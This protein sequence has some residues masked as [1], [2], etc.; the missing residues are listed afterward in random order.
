MISFLWLFDKTWSLLLFESYGVSTILSI[1]VN[2]RQRY[3]GSATFLRSFSKIPTSVYFNSLANR[4]SSF[5]KLAI[6]LH[7]YLFASHSISSWKDICFIKHLISFD[8]MLGWKWF[9]IDTEAWLMFPKI[10]FNKSIQFLE[11]T[12]FFILPQWSSLLDFFNYLPHC[13]SYPSHSYC[14]PH[15][16]ISYTRVV[17]VLSIL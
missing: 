2:K 3:P 12:S 15:H 17:I 11:S 6:V 5:S 1:K 7:A 14:L 13:S 4:G 16:S 10:I 9:I 8:M